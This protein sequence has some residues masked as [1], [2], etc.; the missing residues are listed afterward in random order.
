MKRN[1]FFLLLISFSIASRA[2]DK[3]E[4]PYLTKTFANESIKNVEAETSGG[5]ITVMGVAAGQARVEV[6]VRPNDGRNSNSLSKEEIQKR[7]DED[8][9]LTV[10]VANNKL[11][12]IAETKNKLRVWKKGLSI[13]FKIY[14][15]GDVSTELTTSGG[16]IHLTDLT[17]NQHFTTSG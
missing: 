17:G 8:Y 6:F 1:L 9:K 3:N 4:V 12:T 5:S 7:L 11:T 14:V 13:S 16:S 2:Q 10:S 15:P